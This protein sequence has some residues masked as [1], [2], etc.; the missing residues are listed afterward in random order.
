MLP[1]GP[2][3]FLFPYK[4]RWLSLEFVI[5]L[6]ALRSSDGL[7]GR[8]VLGRVGW[9]GAEAGHLHLGGE[10]GLVYCFNRDFIDNTCSN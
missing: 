10:G 9:E 4:L 2:C 5:T 8:A 6:G 1:C 3:C 7:M